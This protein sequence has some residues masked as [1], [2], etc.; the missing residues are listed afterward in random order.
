MDSEGTYCTPYRRIYWTP[1]I[2]T[3]EAR[4][5]VWSAL[6]DHTATSRTMHEKVDWFVA[7]QIY[8]GTEQGHLKYPRLFASTIAVTSLGTTG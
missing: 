5:V 4:H 6:Q 2:S 8:S 1:T 7:V 3:Q